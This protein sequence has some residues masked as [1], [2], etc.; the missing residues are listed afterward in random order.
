MTYLDS[1]EAAKAPVILLGTEAVVDIPGE[2]RL[3]VLLVDQGDGS[4]GTHIPATAHEK[5]G[6]GGGTVRRAK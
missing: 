1:H 3:R 4:Q 2:V 5:G 6:R